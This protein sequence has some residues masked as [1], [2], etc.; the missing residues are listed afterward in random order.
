[1]TQNR[2]DSLFH[3]FPGV[4]ADVWKK[5]AVTDLGERAFDTI[6]WHTPDGFDLDPW[7]AHREPAT[8][9]DLPKTKTANTW[10]SCHRIKVL[11]PKAANREAL[12]ALNQDASALEFN[13]SD[14]A[15]CSGAGLTTLFAGIETSAITIYFSGNL[16]PLHD[17]LETLASLSGFNASTGGV[18]APLPPASKEVDCALFQTREALPG[19][20]LLCVD[21]T[22]Y[23]NSG[24]TAA[25]E[26]ALALAGTS[27]IMHRFL[28]AG[29]PAESIVSAIELILPVGSSH[30]TELAKP[31]ALR[32][33]LPHLLKAYGASGLTL[34]SLFAR[35]S[36]R[37]R[38]LL[39]PYTN[40]LRLTTESVSAILGGYDTLQI[41]R[42][43]DGL[44]VNPEV[45]AR[46]TGNIHLVLKEEA[47]LDRV[48]DPASGSDYIETLTGKL[49]ASA[50]KIFQEIETDGGLEEAEKSGC[51][52]AMTAKSAIQRES[53]LNKRKKTL[54]GVNRYP[55]GLTAEQEKNIEA[56]TFAAEHSP[57]GSETAAFER[58]RLKTLSGATIPSLFIW[59][60]GDSATS[61]RQAAF[62]EDLFKCGGFVVNGVA[63]LPVEEPSYE[64]I[65][66]SRPDIVVLCIAEKDPVPLAET[67]C[68]QLSLLQP[69]LITIMAGK[70]PVEAER[71]FK[72]G[73]DSFVYTGINVLDTLTS[74]QRKTGVQ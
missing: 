30:F 57:E 42:F 5:R 67:I 65:L 14:S 63:S 16:P 36:E 48:V 3:E 35:T 70:P 32:A 37:N 28:E 39:D 47:W 23:H 38:S 15:N 46:I 20:S 12:N 29:V 7:Y 60:L 2:P 53:L 74:C 27:D 19:F 25:Q 18:L 51:I 26:I 73:L 71:L 68:K 41:G 17:L 44:S 55:L 13:F 6:V 72:A 59:T 40:L 43:D 22:R 33:L 62:C 45:A 11:D 8:R 31:R 56:I 54:L 24:S 64:T 34:P 58:L 4:S 66:H 50:W 69:E 1:M 49:A 52:T 10:K 9:I 21:T 61:L